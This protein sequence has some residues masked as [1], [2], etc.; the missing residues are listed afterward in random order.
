MSINADGHRAGVV[1]SVSGSLFSAAGVVRHH[2]TAHGLAR[3]GL[4]ARAG[5]YL[6]LGYLTLRLVIVPGR[7]HSPDDAQGVMNQIA[8]SPAGEVALTLASVGFLAFALV[9]LATAWHDRGGNWV[10]RACSAGQGLTYVVMA[11]VPASFL[12]GNHDAGSEMQEHKTTRYLLHLPVGQFLVA[13]L[14]LGLL[15]SC[16]WQI[17]SVLQP[18][19]ARGL[20]LRTA[21]RWVRS[22]LRSIAVIGIIARALVFVPIAV[23]LILAAVTNEAS[24][25]TGLNDE[26]E[27]L[28]D[29]LWG[30]CLLVLVSLSFGVFALYSCLES[31][32]KTMQSSA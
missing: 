15:A 24:W 1:D 5:F 2:P 11:T 23:L 29:S 32:Y 4:V 18:D 7:H 14:G 25:Q 3:M 26:L 19:Y 28:S 22:R 20:D 10:H 17:R 31:R 21:P 27:T 16:C 9:R 12:L 13:V 30:S 6:V 8:G